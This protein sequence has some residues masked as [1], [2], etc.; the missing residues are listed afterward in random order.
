[1]MS[2]YSS[3]P[4]SNYDLHSSA[5]ARGNADLLTPQQQHRGVAASQPYQFD[6]RQQAQHQAYAVPANGHGEEPQQLTPGAAEK[7]RWRGNR[8]RKACD[9]CSI[10]K[11]RV[12]G[13]TSPR[14]NWSQH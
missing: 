9:S 3:G 11:V 10:R 13:I 8:L 4:A 7:Q 2:A 14:G 5:A 1:M 12:S 6:P